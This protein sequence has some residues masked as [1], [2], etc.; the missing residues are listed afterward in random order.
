M[1]R[2][3]F[4][5]ERKEH[6]HTLDGKPLKGTTTVLSVLAKVLTWWA[7]GLAVGEFGW[8][9]PKEVSGDERMVV[10]TTRHAEIKELNPDEYLALLDKAYKAHSVRLSKTADAGTDMHSELEKYVKWCISNND[11]IPTI[12]EGSA[13]PQ[14]KIFADWAIKN[15]VKFLAAEGHGYNERL[16]VGGKF[17]LLYE[18]KENRLVVMDFKSKKEAYMSDFFQC[19]GNDLQ[20][21]ES[22]VLDKDGNELLKLQRS[23]AYYGIFPFG[24][25]NPEPQ[26]HFDVDGAKRGFEYCVGLH[27]LINKNG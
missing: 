26:F 11:G 10:A 5:D 20:I 16:W 22:G 8:T 6:L 19:A 15:V 1:N 3:K 21:S 25:K 9:N 18:D 14:V 23:V 27:K 12:A 2:Y 7:S 13:I 24:M 4:I 17:D